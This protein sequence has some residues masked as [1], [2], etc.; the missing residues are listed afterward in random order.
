MQA[1]VAREAAEEKARQIAA[2]EVSTA[3]LYLLYD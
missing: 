1:R 3:T 2:E